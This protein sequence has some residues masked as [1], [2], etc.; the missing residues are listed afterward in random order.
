MFTGTWSL[1]AAWD[2]TNENG[3]KV[4]WIDFLKLRYSIGNPGNQNFDAYMSSGIYEYNPEY[5]NV[6]GESAILL[7]AAKQES[8]MAEDPRPE[9]RSGFH[10]LG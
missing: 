3:S 1:G 9:L 10:C 8:G 6:F 4:K 7:K 5:T 2:I